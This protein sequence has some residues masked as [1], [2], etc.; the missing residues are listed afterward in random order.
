[1]ILTNK[2]TGAFVLMPIFGLRR[3][4]PHGCDKNARLSARILS[5]VSMSPSYSL[6][7]IA[8]RGR[9]GIFC[10][11]A[12]TVVEPVEQRIHPPVRRGDALHERAL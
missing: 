10:K 12:Q 7:A 3:E 8:S 11:S 6:D 9:P 4:F 1:L 5:V 2:R